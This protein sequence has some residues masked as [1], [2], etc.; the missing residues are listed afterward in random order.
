MFEQRDGM[1]RNILSRTVPALAAD[2]AQRVLATVLGRAGVGK[3]DVATWILHAGG[4]D[5]L[6]AVEGRRSGWM[7]GGTRLTRRPGWR[8]EAPSRLRTRC[9][10]AW[11]NRSLPST[12]AP[13]RFPRSCWLSV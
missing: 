4:R 7:T 8:P 10:V 11:P 5:V 2:Y 1:L 13:A 3:R 12:P 9:T 6:Q